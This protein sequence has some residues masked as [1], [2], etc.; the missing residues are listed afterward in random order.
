[1]AKGKKFFVAGLFGALAVSVAGVALGGFHFPEDTVGVT[2]DLSD[3]NYRYATG[4]LG[5]THNT[6][7]GNE[8]I[9][10]S[11]I[12]QLQGPVVAG[13]EYVFTYVYCYARDSAGNYNY[14]YF[15][16][17]NGSSENGGHIKMDWTV[18]SLN[19]DSHLFFSKGA[20]DVCRE[21]Q[22]NHSSSF[23]AKIAP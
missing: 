3:P 9:G 22:V 2:V 8:Y 7:D 13:L 23:A 4:N 10:C 5:Y 14:C 19:G 21:I 15:Y 11:T 20:N 18:Q 17:N 1:M 6:T 16:E 12:T